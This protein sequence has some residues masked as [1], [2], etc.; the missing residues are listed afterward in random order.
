[1]EELVPLAERIVEG[2]ESHWDGS[3]EVA[4]FT[5]DAKEAKIDAEHLCEDY[6]D[7]ADRLVVWAA[8][9][10][11]GD[12]D[13]EE[14]GISPGTTDDQILETIEDRVMADAKAEGV[15]VLEGL[16]SY[17]ER[18]RDDA[19]GIWGCIYHDHLLDNRPC[20]CEGESW[21]GGE[22]LSRAEAEEAASGHEKVIAYKVEV[23]VCRMHF[24]TAKIL[25]CTECGDEIVDDGD[26]V[27]WL[28]GDPYCE[29]CCPP[30][31][32]FT[33]SEKGA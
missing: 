27:R 31:S 6:G 17:L 5:A 8:E 16:G 2:Y 33:S 26:E 28:G 24:R 21:G 9:E 11:L 1:M 19:K 32:A 29:S 12:A 15:D 13:D 7:E 23:D 20:T 4:R 30:A 10:W 18:R 22:K 25:A 3:N 14:L